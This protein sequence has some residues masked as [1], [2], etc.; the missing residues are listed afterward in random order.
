MLCLLLLMKLHDRSSKASLRQEEGKKS[1][2]SSRGS[3]SESDTNAHTHTHTHAR[4]PGHH[5]T[6]VQTNQ[7]EPLQTVAA[8]FSLSCRLCISLYLHIFE[9]TFGLDS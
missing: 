3:V 6:P 9:N 8:A 1:Q 4:K 7:R 2:S 5:A